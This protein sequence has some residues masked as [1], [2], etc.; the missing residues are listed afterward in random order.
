M[1]EFIN[2]A[3]IWWTWNMHHWLKGDGCPWR[4]S[5]TADVPTWRQGFTFSHAYIK[6]LSSHSLSEVGQKQS[7]NWENL[8]SWFRQWWNQTVFQYIH[9][10]CNG[11]EVIPSTFSPSVCKRGDSLFIFGWFPVAAIVLFFVDLTF[12]FFFFW[13]T[14]CW[15]V[16]LADKF[17]C[18]T[19]EIN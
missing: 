14:P 1:G 15:A 8:S 10:I 12:P 9:G 4:C 5:G 11:A 2:F 13:M 6:R 17:C 7:N 18:W 3:E 16:S 19:T